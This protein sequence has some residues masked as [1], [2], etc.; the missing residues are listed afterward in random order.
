MEYW[1]IR[2]IDGHT[3]VGGRQVAGGRTATDGD[4]AAVAGAAGGIRSNIGADR[5]YL[6]PP[7]VGEYSMRVV[8]WRGRRCRPVLWT[9]SDAAL[10]NECRSHGQRSAQSDERWCEGCGEWLTLRRPADV[11]QL[12]GQ[13][14]TCITH[15]NEP[16]GITLRDFY[17]CPNF[18]TS[19][20]L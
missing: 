3:T 20:C 4:W 9:G 13:V 12:R 8:D 6:Y 10:A 19:V 1:N 18:N 16:F 14:Y 11:V 2:M 5:S 7:L 17:F 15:L